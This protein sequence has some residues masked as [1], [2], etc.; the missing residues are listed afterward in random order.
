MSKKLLHGHKPPRS[1]W[2]F[3]CLQEENKKLKS[4]LFS[5]IHRLDNVWEMPHVSGDIE[6]FWEPELR[7]EYEAWEAK[8]ENQ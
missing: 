8:C 1:D 2:C 4:H 3:Q 5:A 7:Q 6:S